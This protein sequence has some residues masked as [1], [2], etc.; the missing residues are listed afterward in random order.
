MAWADMLSTRGLTG[1]MT[2][3]TFRCGRGTSY[4]DTWRKLGSTVDIVPLATLQA[5]LVPNQNVFKHPAVD[6]SSSR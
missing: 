2:I 1:R 6:G 3:V 5:R 4:Q